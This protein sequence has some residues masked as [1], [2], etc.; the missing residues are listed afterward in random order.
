MDPCKFEANLIHMTRSK[1]GRL[2]SETLCPKEWRREERKGEENKGEEKRIGRK[3]TKKRGGEEI[4]QR[5]LYNLVLRLQLLITLTALL[6]P[7]SHSFT[8]TLVY[9]L[10]IPSVV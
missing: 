8:Y 1:L 3:E 10:S 2:N 4:P 7:F 9:I 5:Y 6:G